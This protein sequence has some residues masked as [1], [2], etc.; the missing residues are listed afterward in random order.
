MKNVI[1]ILKFISNFIYLLLYLTALTIG[2]VSI[3][4]TTLCTII[5]CP[6]E[7]YEEFVFP[8]IMGFV[9]IISVILD[10]RQRNTYIYYFKFPFP[11]VGLL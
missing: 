9:W 2:I 11:E 1:F 10:Y 3:V 8:A 4:I 6:L 7:N 5:Q